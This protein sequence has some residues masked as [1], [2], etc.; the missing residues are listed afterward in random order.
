M[1]SGQTSSRPA[2]EQ[3]TAGRQGENLTQVNRG[4]DHKFRLSVAGGT[5]QDVTSERPAREDGDADRN[6][7]SDPN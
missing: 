5:V 3:E 7:Y 2:G 6:F 4:G 1:K